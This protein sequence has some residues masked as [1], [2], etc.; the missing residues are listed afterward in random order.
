MVY[1]ILIRVMNSFE[2]Y[3][4]HTLYVQANWRFI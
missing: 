4:W 3:Q 1:Y 2:L